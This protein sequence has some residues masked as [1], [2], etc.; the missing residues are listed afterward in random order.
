MKIKYR[1][2]WYLLILSFPLYKVS[3]LELPIRGVKGV[4]L[5]Q[6]ISAFIILV[7]IFFLST[8][9]IRFTLYASNPIYFW[10]LLF[11]CFMS[12]SVINPF[13][14]MNGG[15]NLI[16][17]FTYWVQ[18]VW[19]AILFF[20]SSQVR[21]R[22]STLQNFVRLYILL[23]LVVSIFGIVQFIFANS[24]GTAMFSN[25]HT[26]F[27][28]KRSVS[29]FKEPRHFG[30]FLVTP[31]AL[32]FWT[33]IQSREWIFNTNW[34]RFLGLGIYIL[35]IIT[36]LSSS[37]YITALVVVGIVVVFILPKSVIFT[38]RV[39]YFSVALL[40]LLTIV[41]IFTQVNFELLL[42]PLQRFMLSGKE[43]SN[44]VDLNKQQWGFPR[45]LK[46]SIIALQRVR[47]H[48]LL[49][50]GLNQLSSSRLAIILPPFHLLASIGVFGF[51]AFLIFAL[52]LTK[53][54]GYLRNIYLKNGNIGDYDLT[55][56]GLIIVV[57]TLILSITSSGWNY[58]GLWFWV[59]LSFGAM[60][61]YNYKHRCT[62]SIGTKRN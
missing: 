41:I 47:S 24:L 30:T 42:D 61:F 35:G 16:N 46:G 3:V 52:K 4:Y 59:Q 45:Y 28:F 27:G 23:A 1:Y 55:T 56:Q 6:I 53:L 37:A 62:C 38:R 43:V 13:L 8:S 14:N 10:L 26:R 22:K 60:I 12:L 2:I 31:L 34:K 9:K 11:I 40:V 25:L 5:H 54:G 29:F 17:F 49:G 57:S 51:S 48:P 50:I 18:V 44:I 32:L 15:S 58:P 21:F 7:F 19:G 33:S 39:L 20:V 36:S